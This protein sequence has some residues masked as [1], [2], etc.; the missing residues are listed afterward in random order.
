MC[1]PAKDSERVDT[2]GFAGMRPAKMIKMPVVSLSSAN[3][4]QLVIAM[5][6]MNVAPGVLD[7]KRSALRAGAPLE[8]QKLMNMPRMADTKAMA[9]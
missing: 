4:I 7:V 6:E 2:I 1:E 3:R 9:S 5:G 8:H